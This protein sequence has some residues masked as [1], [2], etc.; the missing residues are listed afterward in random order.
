LTTETIQKPKGNLLLYIFLK[1]FFLLSRKKI[2]T[3]M[4]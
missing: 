2:L 3:W 1:R 4:S